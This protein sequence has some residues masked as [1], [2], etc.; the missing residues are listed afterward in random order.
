MYIRKKL[1]RKEGVKMEWYEKLIQNL[2]KENQ[3]L[4]DRLER[5]YEEI[6]NLEK[7]LGK[8]KMEVIKLNAKVN[9]L[10]KQ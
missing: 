5:R 3:L 4:L 6:M 7:E 9:S 10:E 1:C 2:E 8:S